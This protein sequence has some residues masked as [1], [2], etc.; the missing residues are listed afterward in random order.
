M[1]ARLALLGTASPASPFPAPIHPLV[2]AG[3]TASMRRDFPSSKR[4]SLRIASSFA[5]YDAR[6]AA[7][8]PREC[9]TPSVKHRMAV[10]KME[11]GK[12]RRRRIILDSKFG[13]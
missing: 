5:S 9:I 10:A 1:R 13:S 11:V 3:T 6:L 8:V 4:K 7:S 2:P 12:T